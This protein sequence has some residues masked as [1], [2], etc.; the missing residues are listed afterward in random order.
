MHILVTILAYTI[1][2]PEGIIFVWYPSLEA[3]LFCN[4][5]VTIMQMV[6]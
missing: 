2:Y 1:G 3:K 4:Q 6:A 5:R